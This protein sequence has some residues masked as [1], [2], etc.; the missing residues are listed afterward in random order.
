[1]KNKTS[2]G[3]QQRSCILGGLKKKIKNVFAAASLTAKVSVA[4][5]CCKTDYSGDSEEE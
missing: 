2:V 5:K 1:M 3:E 4:V